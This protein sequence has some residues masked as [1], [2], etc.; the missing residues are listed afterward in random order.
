MSATSSLFSQHLP[1]L[2]DRLR[3]RS[4]TDFIGQSHLIDDN[5]ILAK[6][7]GKNQFFSLLFW[8]PPGTGKTTLARI[9]AKSLKADIH[10]LSAVSSG[11][12]DLRKIIDQGKANLDL[13][14]STIFF[15]DE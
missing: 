11:V 15:I 12:K 7:L 10:E 1:P 3:P 4:M 6:L 14:R 9:I 2:A 8:G 5:K 13:G